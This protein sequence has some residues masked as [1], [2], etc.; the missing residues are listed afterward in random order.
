MDSLT[1]IQHLKKEYPVKQIGDEPDLAGRLIAHLGNRLP[2]FIKHK[3]NNGTIN[4]AEIQKSDPQAFVKEVS[5]ND[6]AVVI[7]SGLSEFVYRVVRAISTRVVDHNLGV[8]TGETFDDTVRIVAEIFWWFQETGQ[9]FG[10]EYN[11]HEYQKKIA[12]IITT[13]VESFFLAHELGHIIF[14]KED[15]LSFEKVIERLTFGDYKGFIRSDDHPHF[16]EFVSDATAASVLLGIY[17]DCIDSNPVLNNLRYVGIEFGLMIF[18]GLEALEF[19]TSDSHPTFKERIN[20]VREIVRKWTND[21]EQWQNLI[22][23]ASYFELLFERIIETIANPSTSQIEY[24]EDSA[25]KVLEKIEDSLDRHSISLEEKPKQQDFVNV[26][27]D[28]GETVKMPMPNFDF[29][30]DSI[31]PKYSQF[32]MEVSDILSVGYSHVFFEKLA[33]EFRKNIKLSHEQLVELEFKLGLIEK[34]Q[35]IKILKKNEDLFYQLKEFQ[36]TKLLHGYFSRQANPSGEYFFM[37]VYG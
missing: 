5:E 15:K 23:L 12:S 35:R 13:E 21:D 22:Q 14:P 32:Y 30:D 8:E 27:L 3:I 29:N 4:V 11:I 7:H 31:T 24:Y 25:A 9:S 20:S 1:Y 28:S 19:P 2:E 33:K 17:T 10:P 37:K 16:G 18:S 36:K 34:N 6:Y 26:K